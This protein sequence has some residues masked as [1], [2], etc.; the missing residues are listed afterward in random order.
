[1]RGPIVLAFDKRL[2]RPQAGITAALVKADPQAVVQ[3]IEVRDGL[4][5]GIRFAMDVPFATAA[6]RNGSGA[7]VRL[8]L[9][10]THVVGGIGVARMA[11]AAPGLGKTV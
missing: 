5:K 6:G 3:A 11:A 10:G 1:M 7:D 4:P 2:T 9:G 8:R